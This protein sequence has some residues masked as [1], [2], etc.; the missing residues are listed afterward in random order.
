MSKHA[1]RE[2]TVDSHAVVSHEE[3]LEARLR[4]LNEEK[5]FTRLRD[6]LTRQR[7]DLPWERVDK[8]YRFTGPEGGLTLADLFAGRRQLITYHFMFDPSWDAGCPHCSF[9]A[10]HFDG[11]T[12]HLRQ[13]GTSLVAVAEA[14]Y[15]KIAAFRDRMGW[16]FPF[17]SAAGSDFGPD[18]FVVFTPE[19]RAAG[20]AY[21]NYRPGDPGPLRE[22]LSVFYRD[23]DGALFHT[24]S[25]YARGID[26]VNA[27]Y[28]FLDLVPEGRGEDGHDEKQYWVRHHD[29]YEDG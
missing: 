15:E 27:T 29:R 12:A 5:E 11:A 8:Q 21:Y 7:R 6:R 1:E 26:M 24:Y 10:D 16:R 4:L 9:W 19:E 20:H 23:D 14:P 2:S 18:H 17:V 22:G 25:A 28:Q 13:R 3:W